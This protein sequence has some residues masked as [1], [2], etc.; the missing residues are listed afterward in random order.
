[1]IWCFSARGILYS[2]TSHS[3]GFD[4]SLTETDKG[5][6]TMTITMRGLTE[7]DA[8]AVVRMNEGTGADFLY[9]WAGA[10]YGYPLTREQV[11]ARFSRP[12]TKG[13]SILADG[14]V[15]GT[16][17]LD[18]INY[19]TM[20]CSVCRFLIDPAFR[21][22]GIGRESLNRI[23]EAAFDELHMKKVRLSVFD[24]NKN[25]LRCYKNAGFSETG[26]VLR[27][28][29]WKAINMERLNPAFSPEAL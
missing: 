21:G 10:G 3:N 9:Q 24:F 14:A 2:D 13:Y 23:V 11:I 26:W 20:E 18:F 16:F 19:E 4:I 6:I 28:N 8:D 15:I 17:E 29:G 12:Q 27:D 25:A 1:M 5:E 22:K 7:A